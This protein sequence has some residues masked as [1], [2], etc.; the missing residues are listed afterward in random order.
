MKIIEITQD[1]TEKSYSLFDASG[2]NIGDVVENDIYIKKSEKYIIIIEAGTT[3]TK[4]LYTVLQVQ[5]SLYILNKPKKSLHALA[6]GS[7]HINCKTLFARIKRDKKDLLKTLTML[8]SANKKV[9]ADFLEAS[10]NKINLSCI[11]SIVESTIFLIK[12]NENY[13]KNIM[14]KMHNDHKLSIHSLNVMIYALNLGHIL[15]FKHE[16]LL[17]LGQAALLHDIG[18]KSVTYIIDKNTELNKDELEQIYKRVEHSLQILE[19]NNIDDTS[20]VDA[21]KHHQERHDGSGYPNSLLKD[22][23]SEFGSILAICDVFDALTTDRPYRKGY[24]TFE[25]L[26]IM[27]RDPSMK[28]KFNND[29][30]KLGLLS[31]T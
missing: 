7:K 22:D 2:L 18:K 3:L 9:F 26:K 6:G 1:F 19:E 12:N 27:M 5:G 14:P 11:D 10:D 17:K 15:H 24:A 31:I 4:K 29:Y 28:N 20:V 30:L 23:I 21:V 16:Q 8:Y 13:L 25:A